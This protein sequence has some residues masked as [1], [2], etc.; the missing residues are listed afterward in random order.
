MATKKKAAPVV[1]AAEAPKAVK[2]AKPAVKAAAKAAPAKRHTK[3]KAAV[4]ESAAAVT[5]SH[6]EIS[7]LAYSYFV[8]RGYQGGNEVED[9]LRAEREIRE[10]AGN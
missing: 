3:A 4:A 10:R 6:E 1:E 7:R 2:A 5:V 9:W 8:E